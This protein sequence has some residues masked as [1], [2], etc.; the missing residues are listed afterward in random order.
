[1][2]IYCRDLANYITWIVATRYS[3]LLSKKYQKP[4]STFLKAFDYGPSPDNPRWE[5][6]IAEVKG[7]FGM[8]IGRMFVDE[9]FRNGTK[10]EVK[11]DEKSI[12]WEKFG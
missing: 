8:A 10:E 7:H 2:K 9:V 1:M 12:S 4:Y 6:C 11:R 5:T 3:K